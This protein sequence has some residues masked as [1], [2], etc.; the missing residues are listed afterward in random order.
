MLSGATRAL[1]LYHRFDD[2][3]IDAHS[4]QAQTIGLHT[5]REQLAWP[6]LVCSSDK[7]AVHADCSRP[8]HACLSPECIAHPSMPRC[9]PAHDAAPG[10]PCS[11]VDSSAEARRPFNN[12]LCMLQ[13][14]STGHVCLLEVSS[15]L[16]SC[17][18]TLYGFEVRCQKYGLSS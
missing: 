6:K 7:S 2:A 9:L 13:V 11:L 4:W 1:K 3:I 5:Q 17:S 10:M 14:E 12:I 15:S 8:V 16:P 18:G